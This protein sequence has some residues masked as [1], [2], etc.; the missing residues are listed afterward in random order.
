M[1]VTRQ[2]LKH[3]LHLWIWSVGLQLLLD[4]VVEYQ[5]VGHQVVS[6]EL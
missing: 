6:D 3:H 2:P 1:L 5:A 4:W